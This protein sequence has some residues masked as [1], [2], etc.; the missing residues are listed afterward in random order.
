MHEDNYSYL[1]IDEASNTAAAVD[2]AEPAKVM[3]AATKSG[4]TIKMVL[5]THKHWDHSGGN[6]EM[7][8]KIPG[9]VASHAYAHAY[10]HAHAQAHVHLHTHAHAHVYVHARLERYSRPWPHRLQIIGR[11]PVLIL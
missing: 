9:R 7:A 8:S 10:T 4:V 3:A 5:T 2:P 11:Y 6:S 1:V